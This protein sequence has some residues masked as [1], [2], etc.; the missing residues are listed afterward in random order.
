[1][2]W[3]HRPIAIVTAVGANCLAASRCA[4]A[5]NDSSATI[6]SHYAPVTYRRQKWICLCKN[7]DCRLQ[8]AFRENWIGA[9][10]N[11]ILDSSRDALECGMG[12]VVAPLLRLRCNPSRLV[13]VALRRTNCWVLSPEI[14]LIS[15]DSYISDLTD[16]Y[17]F[18]N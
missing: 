12:A 15:E 9:R 18:M 2:V 8:A 10:G 13:L 5:G 3:C 11:W 4:R 14:K 17:S 16:I 6:S 1:M 7:N